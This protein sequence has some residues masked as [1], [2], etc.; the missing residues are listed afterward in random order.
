V[1][2]PGRN[3]PCPCGSG[4]KFKH[5]CLPALETPPAG[6]LRWRRIRRSLENMAVTLLRYGEE[7]YGPMF[8]GFA[9]QNFCLDDEAGDMPGDTPHTQVFMPWL[10]FH[11]MP[12]PDCGE[13]K[14]SAR[15]G[16]TLAQAFLRD[17]ASRIEAVLAEYLRAC[18]DAPMSFYDVMSVRAGAGVR[19]RDIF[20]GTEIEVTENAGSRHMRE[21]DIVFAKVAR[22]PDLAMFEALAPVCIPPE[23]REPI[24]RLRKRMEKRKRPIN[25]STR[26][27]WELD[28]LSTYWELVEPILN[29]PPPVFQN[30]DGD[31]LLPQTV[32]YDIAS[33]QAA[34]D[35][36]ADLCILSDREELLEEGRRDAKGDLVGIRFDWHKAGNAKHREW[37]NTIM[38]KLEIDGSRLSADVNSENRAMLF[39]RLMDERL[40]DGRYRTTVMQPVESALAERRSRPPTAA[41]RKAE[42]EDKAFMA[43]PEIQAMMAEQMRRHYHAWLDTPIP[44]LAI[45]TPRQAVKNRDGRE[46]VEGLLLGVERQVGATPGLDRELVAG[47][48]RELGLQ[49]TR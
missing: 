12:D 26:K 13:I 27:E 42:E 35:A 30:T 16:L 24:L 39:R 37:T 36:L 40:P 5:C 19:V 18:C 38:G 20:D 10:F 48:R 4:K 44:A 2:K 22:L 25:Q 1:S 43:Q 15:D 49:E 33:P 45:K 7:R 29:P 8:L 11:W 47:L 28:L 3:D 14:A 41:E 32:V 34:F 21:G 9:W 6:E 46:M 23:R 17:R 31:P